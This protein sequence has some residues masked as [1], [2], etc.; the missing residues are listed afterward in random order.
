MVL[1][2][3]PKPPEFPDG[4]VVRSGD[5]GP[6]AEEQTPHVFGN[7]DAGSRGLPG[8]FFVFR[9]REAHRASVLKS[10]ASSAVFLHTLSVFFESVRSEAPNAPGESRGA[11]FGRMSAVC[12]TATIL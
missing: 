2:Q 6:A 10:C 9:R 12:Q 3:A 4:L 11:A 7:R 5:D 1:E 8:Q